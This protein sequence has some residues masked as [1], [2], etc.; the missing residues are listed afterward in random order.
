MRKSKQRTVLVVDDEEFIGSILKRMLESVGHSVVVCSSSVEALAVSRTV[1]PELVISDFNLPGSQ[2]GVDLCLA[3]RQ[4]A[5]RNVP[6][7]IISGQTNNARKSRQNGFA[8][9]GKPLKKMQLLNLVD[10]CLNYSA[11]VG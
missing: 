6:A 2:D 3:I 10:S 9:L 5:R 4:A 7:I 1:E 11:P 8:F